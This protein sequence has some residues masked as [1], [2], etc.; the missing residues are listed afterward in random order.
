MLASFTNTEDWIQD[1]QFINAETEDPLAGVD[2][3]TAAEVELRDIDGDIVLT[4]TLENGAVTLPGSGV[5]R[6]TF[7]AAAVGGLV[8]GTHEVWV[9]LTI[10]GVKTDM[11][12]DNVTVFV[13][14]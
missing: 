1:V 9:S 12:L 2:T 14:V 8:P 5:L 7:P 10:G 6:W 4:G 3:A 11:Y 13:G